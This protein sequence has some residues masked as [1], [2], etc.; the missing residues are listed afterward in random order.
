[1]TF[2][3]ISLGYIAM[4]FSTVAYNE[5]GPNIYP[6]LVLIWSIMTKSKNIKK[7]KELL[8]RAT[9]IRFGFIWELIENGLSLNSV[10]P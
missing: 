7:I 4:K 8:V 3:Y 1:M 2:P 10:I 6:I 9:L 5:L